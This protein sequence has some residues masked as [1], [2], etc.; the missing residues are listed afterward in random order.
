MEKALIIKT[1]IPIP[2]TDKKIKLL[3]NIESRSMHGQ[4]PIVW[5]RAEGYKV[6]DSA[7]NCWI[8]FTSTIFVTNTGHSNKRIFQAIKGNLN[9]QLPILWN[10]NKYLILAS[11]LSSILIPN[12]FKKKS[13]WVKF[14]K[15]IML[16][17]IANK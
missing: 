6:Y 4:L 14:S 5:D 10:G 1:K 9:K 2:N 13:K 11:Y 3:N 17:S 7:G 16:L 15:E 12:Y 8:D